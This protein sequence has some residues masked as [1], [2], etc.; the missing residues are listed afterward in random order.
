[1]SADEVM[2]LRQLEQEYARQ[3]DLEVEVMKGII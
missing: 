3:R 1:M 2:R